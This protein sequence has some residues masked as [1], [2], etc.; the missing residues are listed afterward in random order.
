VLDT[1]FTS[2]SHK[3]T[4]CNR[5]A[6]GFYELIELPKF[7]QTQLLSGNLLGLDHLT[8]TVH[9]IGADVVTQTSFASA[10][11]NDHVRSH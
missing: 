11:V 8:A 7:G 3:K 6:A 10:V 5:L 2:N 1:H 9:A 4:R